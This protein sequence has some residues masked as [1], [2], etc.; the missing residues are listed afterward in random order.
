MKLLI[1]LIKGIG[2]VIGLLIFVVLFAVFMNKKPILASVILF[3]FFIIIAT[4][5]FYFNYEE[6]I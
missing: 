3:I 1:A 2:C 4:L 5:G 6:L